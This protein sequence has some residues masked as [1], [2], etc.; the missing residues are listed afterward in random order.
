MDYNALWAEIQA[1]PACAPHIYTNDLPKL[2]GAEVVLKDQAIADIISIGRKKIVHTPIG[3]GTIMAVMKP[4]GGAFLNTLEAM[5]S[6]D[7]NVKWVMI[8][9]N[10]GVYDIGNPAA[11][12]LMAKFCIDHPEMADSIAALMKIPEQDDP[13]TAAD[14][15]RAVRGPRE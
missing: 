10:R 9:I 14:V 8:L 12:E 7:A 6:S 5:A 2:P 3:P 15:S 13:V 1:N 4:N 11:Q